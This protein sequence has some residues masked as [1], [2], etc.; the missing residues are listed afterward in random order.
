MKLLA[1]AFVLAALTAPAWAAPTDVTVDVPMAF[2]E[3]LTSTADG[4]LYI[5]SMNLGAVYRVPPGEKTAKPWI[6]K[7]AGNFGRVLGVLANSGT[8]YVCDNNGN[9]AYLKTF[10]L[11]TAA[12]MKTYELPG[13][14][15]CN[16]IALKGKD[17]YL[18]DTKGGRVLKLAAG[19]DALNVWYTN[20]KSDA[21]LD[22]LV[23]Q[24]DALYTNTYNG[25]NLI[26]IAMNPDGS[27]GKGVNLTTS[28]DIYQPD[29]MRL[30]SDG[31]ILMVEGRGKDTS[32]RLE[33]VTVSGDHATIRV[34]KDKYM[35]PT[36]VTVVGNTAYVLEAKLN[37][38][39]DP[40]LKDKDPGPFTAYAVP[41]K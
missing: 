20:D 2:P 1:G 23:W 41:L 25:N 35:L 3:S 10:S 24:G 11:K 33:E 18:T 19:S 17:A 14:G 29:G 4:T 26:R 30:S 31:K 8:L 39:R 15:F 36:A 32:G 13:G 37:Y 12:L 21:S 9:N 38:Q 7:E 5:G 27:A 28:M 22:G 6:S 16:D 34:I 40:A